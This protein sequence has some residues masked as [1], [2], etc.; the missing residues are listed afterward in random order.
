MA[1]TN[2]VAKFDTIPEAIEAFARGEFIVVLDATN[3][4][5]EGDLIIAAS[6]FTAAKAAFMIRHTSGLICAPILPS[7]AAKLE[8]PQMVAHN[9][10]PKGTAYTITIDA[11][12][13]TT[14]GIS[15]HDRALT[16]RWLADP[17]VRIDSFRR[18]G[19]VIPLQARE[20]GV[21][22]R[23]GHTEAAVEF[24]LLAGKAPVAVIAELVEDGEEVLGQGERAGEY[25]MMRRDG[26]LAFAK[27]Y[28]LKA[29]TIEDLI[30][31][32]DGAKG[33]Q[34]N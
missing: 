14:T 32:L 16:C 31:H 11:A 12:E 7:L 3:R 9:T 13:D 28:G 25:G 33:I 22:V 4:E 2:G 24:C 19:H 8:L 18:P 23:P 21:R 10:D 27:K 26:C 17:N 6:D 20:G 30:L 29:V 5:N 15:A 1:I 34:R